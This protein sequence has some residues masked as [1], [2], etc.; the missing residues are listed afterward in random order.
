MLKKSTNWLKPVPRGCKL[1]ILQGGT[2]FSLCFWEK[3]G[4]FQHRL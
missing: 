1:L 3:D 4:L 2:D